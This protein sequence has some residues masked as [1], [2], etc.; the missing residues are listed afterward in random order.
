MLINTVAGMWTLFI[1]VSI[2]IAASGFKLLTYAEALSNRL[3]LGH[4]WAGTIL[5]ATVTS[6]PELFSGLSSVTIAHSA[7]MAIG[8]VL[9]SCVFNLSIVVIIDYFYRGPSFYTKASRSHLLVGA[10]GI[11]L[12]GVVLFSTFLRT[13]NLGFNLAHIGLDSIVIVLIYLTAMK[14][15]YNFEAAI[16][17]SEKEDNFSGLNTTSLAIRYTISSLIVIAAGWVLP[18][19]GTHLVVLMGWSEAF[20]GT[21]FIAFATSLPELAVTFAAIRSLAVDLALSNLLG[22]NLFNIMIL[23]VDDV[24]YLKGPLLQEYKSGHMLTGA[25]SIL[26][27]GLVIISLISPPKKKVF[28]F[29]SAFSFI[30]LFIYIINSIVLYQAGKS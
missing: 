20:V 14:G 22:S 25:S 24:F 7:D 26:M 27:T 15:L 16:E 8:G 13:M 29:V 19:V 5:L 23:A 21:I 28:N 6:F 1:L 2:L 12:I 17:P 9:G 30:I 11:V 18:I 10:I 3:N 4:T